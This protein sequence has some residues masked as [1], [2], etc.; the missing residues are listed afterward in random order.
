MFANII[1]TIKLKLSSSYTI[2]WSSHGIEQCAGTFKTGLESCILRVTALIVLLSGIK[3]QFIR[4]NLRS[5]RVQ[6]AA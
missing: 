5:Y 3:L 1:E 6:S 2:S 4:R